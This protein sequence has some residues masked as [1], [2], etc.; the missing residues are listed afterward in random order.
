MGEVPPRPAWLKLGPT[1]TIVLQANA[2]LSRPF[3]ACY[4]SSLSADAVPAVLAVLPA[5]D[6]E[7]Q[8]IAQGLLRRWSP[9]DED[10]RTWSFGRA[11][12]REMVAAREAELRARL[13]IASEDKDRDA[14]VSSSR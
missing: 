4:A 13:R 7:R 5:L 9:R 14:G 6:H 11:R 12:A 1:E 2:R 8:G 3:D 10:R